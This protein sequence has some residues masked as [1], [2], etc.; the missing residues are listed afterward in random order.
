MMRR[1]SLIVILY[2]ILTLC[3]PLILDDVDNAQASV[4]YVNM[5]GGADYIY[6]QNAI[7]KATSG[8][9]I[10]VSNGSYN[11]NLVINKSIQLVGEYKANTTINGNNN[12][13][14]TIS[15]AT[16]EI[17]GFTIKNSNRGINLVNSSESTIQNNTF[18]DNQYGIHTDENSVN[19]SIY[20]NNFVNNTYNAYDISTNFW[21]Q[22]L[23]GNFWDDYTG[24]DENENSIGDTAYNISGGK[25]KDL[26]PLTQP[27]TQDP[28][29]DFSFNP[30]SPTTQ[31]M[32]TF[33]DL[34]TDDEGII[35]WSW[36]FGDN[37]TSSLEN[38]EHLY[39]D[40]GIYQINLTVTDIVGATDTYSMSLSVRNIAPKASFTFAPQQP[41]DIQ[42]VFFD[43]TSTDDDGIIV[44]WS[45]DFGDGNKT[46]G[47]DISYVFPD[48]GTYII[49]LRVTDDDSATATASETIQVTNVPPTASFTYY[50][51]EETFI[52]GDT[53]RFSDHSN[54]Q[55]GTILS[56]MW[57]FDDGTTSTIKN[58]THIYEQSGSYSVKLSITD[59]DGSSNH[60]EKIVNIKSDSEGRDWMTSF[61]TFDIVFI[62]FLI[63]MVSLVIF[64]SR[65]Y[66]I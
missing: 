55:D 57:D 23:T 50:S 16:V 26:Y 19:N 40:N 37:T 5:S 10:L 56:W 60:Y 59:N 18:I 62:I 9:T 63:I 13:A 53:I 17:T 28:I 41:T 29:A 21:Y 7:E 46:Y 43:D 27:V 47:N 1:W 65:K 2:F 44:N 49:T 54:D 11:E 66:K 58:P 22:S 32:I 51:D 35:S 52:V 8:D 20:G 45:W 36:D 12:N 4:I 61:S 31:D 3:H 15:S 24:I 33:T 34:S 48:N 38:P 39:S 25:N 30:L 64:L 14:I 42:S 6:I